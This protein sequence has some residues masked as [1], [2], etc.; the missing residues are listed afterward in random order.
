MA[1]PSPVGPTAP[2]VL[3]VD[4]EEPNLESLGKIFEREGWRV[5]LAPSGQA[6]LDVLRGL[7]GVVSDVE[8]PLLDSGLRPEECFRL[9]WEFLHF[10]SGRYGAMLVPHG[11]TPAARRLVPMSARLRQMLDLRW[12]TA[13]KPSHGWIFTAPTTSGHVEPST[14]RGLHRKAI[15]AA[16]LACDVAQKHL[17]GKAPKKLIV[18]PGRLVNIVA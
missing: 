10:D 15:E 12:T 2:L 16:A 8:I 13:K 1:Y 18:V 9:R 17:E 5:A 4:D 3:I 14:I 11:K 7:G 6:A